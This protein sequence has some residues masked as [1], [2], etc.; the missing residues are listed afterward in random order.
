MSQESLHSSPRRKN[1]GSLSVRGAKF[2]FSTWSGNNEQRK[3]FLYFFFSFFFPPSA[4]SWMSVN[5]GSLI[6]VAE[7]EESKPS[8]VPS[9]VMSEHA[10]SMAAIPENTVSPEFLTPVS[11]TSGAAPSEAAVSTASDYDTPTTEV[12]TGHTE[13]SD[14]NFTE[15]KALQL[16][17]PAQLEDDE[18]ISKPIDLTEDSHHIQDLIILNPPQENGGTASGGEPCE[19]NTDTK[20]RLIDKV[21]LINK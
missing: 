18:N 11:E 1:S 19:A 20:V 13:G 3:N 6:S 9:D 12:P 2:I 16:I 21:S 7:T 17:E 10:L 15:S 14:I 5:S 4:A 8:G